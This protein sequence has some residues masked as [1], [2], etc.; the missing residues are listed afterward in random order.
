MEN[1]KTIA[2][3]VDTNKLCVCQNIP[4]S[5]HPDSTKDYP[6][7]GKVVL[8]TKEILQNLYSMESREGTKTIKT[9]LRMPH[10][11]L[12]QLRLLCFFCVWNFKEN[13]DII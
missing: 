12:F 11:I 2:A 5:D 7:V 9:S 6:E 10:D 4:L 8:A 13:C 3:I 1:R